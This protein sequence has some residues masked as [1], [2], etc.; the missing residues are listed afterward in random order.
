IYDL[1]DKHVE[2]QN[3]KKYRPFPIPSPDRRRYHPSDVSLIVPTVDADPS[4]F[5]ACLQTWSRCRPGEI[6]LVTTAGEQQARVGEMLRGLH[7]AA[8]IDSNEAMLTTKVEL[9]TV[10]MP[11][12]RHQLGEILA[13]VDDDARWESEETLTSL[14]APFEEGDVGVVGGRLTALR[15]RA[16]R[17]ARMKAAYAA[18]G[19]INFCVSGVT[20]LAR[21]RILRDDPLFRFA[22]VHERWSGRRQ[23]SGDDTFIT[24]WCLFHHLLD[25]AARRREMV[26]QLRKDA[27]SSFSDEEGENEARFVELGR[28][29]ELDTTRWRLGIQMTE[30]ATVPTYV[31][32]GSEFAGQMKRWCRSGLRLRLTCLLFEPGIFQMYK[33]TPYITRKMVECMFSPFLQLLYIGCWFICLRQAPLLGLVLLLHEVYKW[34]G[35]M[36]SFVGRFPYA[37][38]YWWAAALVEKVQAISDFYCWATLGT[39]TWET[40]NTDGDQEGDPLLL[41]GEIVHG[42]RD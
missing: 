33:T 39:E 42:K 40:R 36:F 29:T 32:Q 17:H 14:L 16:T 38:P 18:D 34:A 19:G 25:H 4:T 24:R 3:E 30:E 21:A 1:Y 22:F 11:N 2:A 31:K 20:M 26:A 12:K 37:A 35:T 27:D 9:L 8:K 10:D 13:L 6:I 7:I 41:V 5:A 28:V 23:N 15:L